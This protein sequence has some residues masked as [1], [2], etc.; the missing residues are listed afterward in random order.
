M[1]DIEKNVITLVGYS[2][3]SLILCW[4]IK[5]FSLIKAYFY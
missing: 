1:D 2:E 4:L 3:R 5:Q